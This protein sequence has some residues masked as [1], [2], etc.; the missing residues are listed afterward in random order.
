MER[1]HVGRRLCPR[2]L[3][4]CQACAECVNGSLTQRDRSAS[5]WRATLARSA[6]QRIDCSRSGLR[7]ASSWLQVFCLFSSVAAQSACPRSAAGLQGG[8][9]SRPSLHGSD[10]SEIKAWPERGIWLFG[11]CDAWRREVGAVRGL[12]FEL[13]P[14]AEAGAVSPGCDDLTGGAA[15]AYSACRSESGVERGV[16]PHSARRA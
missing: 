5:W 13:T 12:T 4:S 11:A 3:D 14:R 7:A 6:S 10:R 2:L 15:R 9:S 16:R 8:S 1:G